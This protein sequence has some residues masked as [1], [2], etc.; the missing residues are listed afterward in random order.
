[1]S[2]KEQLKNLEQ[3]R[4]KLAKDHIVATL[5]EIFREFPNI[6]IISWG[7]KSSEYND[8]GMYTG[9]HGPVFNHDFTE[10]GDGPA[11]DS[12]EM[13]IIQ[14]YGDYRRNDTDGWDKILEAPTASEKLMGALNEIG[15]DLLV[16]IFDA[17]EYILSAVR[18]GDRFKIYQESVRY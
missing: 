12:L 15:E 16:D 11:W 13:E 17:D 4:H 8:E 10:G 18:E 7:Q 9:I 5:T 3:D 6:N 14:G 1:M 2:L